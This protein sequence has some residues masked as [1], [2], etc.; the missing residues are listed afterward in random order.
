MKTPRHPSNEEAAR[1]R[2]RRLQIEWL[3]DEPFCV[4]ARPGHFFEPHFKTI[5]ERT[6]Y[7]KLVIDLP[8]YCVARRPVRVCGNRWH[9]R[10]DRPGAVCSLP[11]AV[12]GVPH[13]RTQKGSLNEGFCKC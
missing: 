7:V 12:F 4:D 5:R 2:E 8:D 6:C 13:F 10:V 1:G 3:A 9:R 11:R